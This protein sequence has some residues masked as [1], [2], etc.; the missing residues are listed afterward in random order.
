M[1]ELPRHED[2]WAYYESEPLLDYVCQVSDM[3]GETVTEINH[4]GS[5][6]STPHL[7]P[8]SFASAY[9]ENK[10]DMKGVNLVVYE[11]SE[12]QDTLKAFGLDSSKFWYLCLFIKWKVDWEFESARVFP[13]EPLEKLKDLQAEFEKIN[14]TKIRG[15][16]VTSKTAELT[17][18]VKGS[19]AYI[20][21]DKDTLAILNNIINDYLLNTPAKGYLLHDSEKV[22]L[23]VATKM[24]L[25][26][27]YLTWFISPLKA[28][29]MI[30]ACK[31]KSL[32]VSRMLYILG[33]YDQ[34]GENEEGNEG[35]ENNEN[36]KHK[37]H[38][39][40]KENLWEEYSEKGN[41][42]NYLKGI[43]SKYKHP[44]YWHF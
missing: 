24:Y 13:K 26:N 10:I 41:K 18:K 35:N 32:L 44:R 30:H 15:K 21:D 20:I 6:E 43:L 42:K 12:I 22:D 33:V 17:F 14:F 39:M 19:K 40:N 8:S 28:D 29:R 25:F 27:K 9:H 7:L 1:I 36:K 34:D 4:D 3:M 16:Y 38:K 5:Y 23:S 31:D 2:E 11:K 37:K